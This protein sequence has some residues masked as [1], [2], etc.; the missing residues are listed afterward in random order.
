MLLEIRE[1]EP[2]KK[3]STFRI[4]GSAKFFVVAKSK[5]EILEAVAFA[6][7]ENLPFFI[8]GGGSN[9]LFSDEGYNGLIIKIQNNEDKISD[10]KIVVEAGSLL[11]SVVSKTAGV[12][13]SGLEWAAGIP[14]TIGGA[15]VGNAGAFG[16]SMKEIV[17]SVEAYDLESGETR[18][19]DN[20]DC[21][22][23]YRESIF[24]KNRNLIIFSAEIWLEKKDIGFVRA[25][26]KDCL[27]YRKNTQ[28]LESSSGSVFK[29]LKAIREN[30]RIL[31]TIPGYGKLKIHEGGTIPTGFVIEKC[32]LK[33]KKVGGAEIS[34]KHANFIVNKGDATAK[35]VMELIGVIKEKVREKFGFKLEEE[36][37][38]LSV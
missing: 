14:G 26:I 2:L 35:D 17:K 9:I 13:L 38:I 30:L 33:G 29:H 18:I 21:G 1:N 27:V 22:F 34:D 20:N 7:K 8:L 19:F 31:E 5:E 4:G 12:G 6:K 16:E 32:G 10:A 15:I 25:K 11:G 3:Y 24:K 37:K 23:D 36:I 28:P